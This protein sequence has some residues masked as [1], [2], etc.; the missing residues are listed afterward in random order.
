MQ[1]CPKLRMS[2]QTKDVELLLPFYRD[3]L[4]FDVLDRSENV[5]GIVRTS[6]LAVSV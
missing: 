3:G 4:G 2:R 1:N 6:K 5:D